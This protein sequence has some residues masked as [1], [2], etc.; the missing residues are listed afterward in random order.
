MSVNVYTESIC[1]YGSRASLQQLCCCIFRYTWSQVLN[2]QVFFHSELQCLYTVYV[3][4]CVFI[5]HCTMYIYG[6]FS[7]IKLPNKDLMACVDH[8]LFSCIQYGVNTV[9]L[10]KPSAALHTFETVCI[11]VLLLFL[12]YL[13][14]G[15]RRKGGRRVRSQNDRLEFGQDTNLNNWFV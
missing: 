3:Q 8:L 5:F 11:C 15:R 4:C 13:P 14:S 12:P 9:G 7:P 6:I 10:S 2:S 1:T